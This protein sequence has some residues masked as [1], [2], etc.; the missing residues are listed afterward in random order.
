MYSCIHYFPCAHWIHA[1]RSI[2]ITYHVRCCSNVS[3]CLNKLLHNLPGLDSG[4]AVGNELE[5]VLEPANKD[6]KW[7]R[8]YNYVCIIHFLDSRITLRWKYCRISSLYSMTNGLI[9]S[10][11]SS[12]STLHVQLKWRVILVQLSIAQCWTS[13]LNLVL[14]TDG[15]MTE[16]FINFNCLI[17]A[18]PFFCM[19][20]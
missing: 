1:A 11:P 17:N 8:I 13:I 2:S 12:W 7:L 15:F 3:C 14:W 5:V 9:P 6:I 4:V 20:T 10:P 16:L 19:H 18:I